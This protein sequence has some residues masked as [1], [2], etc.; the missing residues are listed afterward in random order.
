QLPPLTLSSHSTARSADYGHLHNVP[1]LRSSDL[2]IDTAKPTNSFALNSASGA[3]L[4]GSTLYYKSDAA[5]SLKL[6]DTLADTGGSG[7]KDDSYPTRVYCCNHTSETVVIGPG[8]RS[9]TLNWS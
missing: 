6:D 2:D 7:V 3:Y 4:T 8:F 9:A 1:A 5:G